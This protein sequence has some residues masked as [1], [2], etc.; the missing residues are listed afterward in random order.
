MPSLQRLRDRLAPQGLEVLAVNF[1][2]NAARI[3]PFVERLHFTVPVLRDHD[4]SASRAWGVRVYP[5]TFIV[6]PD[7][8]IVMVAIGEIDWSDP[9]IVRR[10]RALTGSSTTRSAS[11]R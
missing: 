2:E 5:T 9:A 11:A 8:R 1:Q 10:L 6:G 7:Q 4:G 3:R